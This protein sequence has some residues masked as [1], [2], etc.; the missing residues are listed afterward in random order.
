MAASTLTPV[1]GRVVS[2]HP[3][4]DGCT[5]S[6]FYPVHVVST[7]DRGFGLEALCDVPTKTLLLENMA[8]RLNAR[9]GEIAFDVAQFL[10]V[11]PT[12]YRV[13]SADSHYLMVCGEMVFL[14]HSAEPNCSVTWRR[15]P[16][17]MWIAQLRTLVPIGAGDELLI[18]YTDQDDY[19]QR[20][21]I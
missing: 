11:D 16:E 10:F 2:T 1:Q 15:G 9:N 18:T 14:N 17:G 19:V 8:K 12:P 6:R 3:I 21:R 4:R 5:N 20:G 7:P 13:R